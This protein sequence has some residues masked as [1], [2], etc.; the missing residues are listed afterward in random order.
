[1]RWLVGVLVVGAS[2]Q[3]QI[4]CGASAPKAN[5]PGG[6][7]TTGTSSTS[8]SSAP[9]DDATTAPDVK[10]LP[11]PAAGDYPQSSVGDHECWQS[12][13]LADDA[14]KDFAAIV[15]ACGKP[16]GMLPVIAPVKGTLG[17]DHKRDK[18]AISLVGGRCYR[19]FAVGTAAIGD[20]D[21]RIESTDGAIVA[22][23]QSTH[24]VAIID[25]DK[26]LCVTDTVDYRFVLEVDGPGQG[27]YMFGVWARPK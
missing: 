22:I 27:A 18:L 8:E 3:L 16:T 5:G 17:P 6:A 9:K 12:V 24:P 10:V 23:D 2:V 25:G 26:P 4:A 19:F 21:I 15:A 1:M 20:V 13:D 7:S 11:M 14:P